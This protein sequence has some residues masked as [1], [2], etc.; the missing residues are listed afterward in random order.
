M[1]QCDFS[2]RLYEPACDS[3][4]AVLRYDPVD[5]LWRATVNHHHSGELATEPHPLVASFTASDACSQWL[6]IVTAALM[7]G[8]NG[9]S[10]P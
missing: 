9:W 5:R 8:D 10:S 3:L 4:Y 1:C 7:A 6:C 2:D